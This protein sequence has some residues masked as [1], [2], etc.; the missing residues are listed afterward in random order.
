MQRGGLSFEGRQ[1]LAPAHVVSGGPGFQVWV[2]MFSPLAKWQ[3]FGLFKNLEMGWLPGTAGQQ[4]A[5]TPLSNKHQPGSIWSPAKMYID[6]VDQLLQTTT[7]AGPWPASPPSPDV[8]SRPG[9]R[10]PLCWLGKGASLPHFTLLTH[11]FPFLSPTSFILASARIARF[12]LH[13]LL[14]L[15]LP[16]RVTLPLLF[17]PTLKQEK[18]ESLLLPH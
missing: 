4:T 15:S 17:C 5:K 12:E 18:G 3:L 11:P 13:H 9:C 10:K 16:A 1:G 7:Q 2:G 8:C 14:A 6:L